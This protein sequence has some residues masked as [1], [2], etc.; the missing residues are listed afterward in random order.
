M[1]GQ[2]SLHDEGS[3]ARVYLYLK[4]RLDGA[5]RGSVPSERYQLSSRVSNDVAGIGLEDSRSLPADRKRMRVQSRIFL[6]HRRNSSKV[7]IDAGS[8]R[9]YTTKA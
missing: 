8:S 1:D 4:L 6:F 9:I 2:L 3:E 7:I 5:P